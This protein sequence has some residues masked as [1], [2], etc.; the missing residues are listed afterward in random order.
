MIVVFLIL[1]K[2]I[3]FGIINVQITSNYIT[4]FHWNQPSNKWEQ[5]KVKNNIIKDDNKLS[6]KRQIGKLH[7]FK[8]SFLLHI[9]DPWKTLSLKENKYIVL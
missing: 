9:R 6:L 5:N 2:I 8:D 7:V 4:D 1:M 3:G